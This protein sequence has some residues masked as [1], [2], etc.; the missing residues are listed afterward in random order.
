MKRQVLLPRGATQRPAEERSARVG[1]SPS[2]DVSFVRP[3][4]DFRVAV[5]S[6]LSRIPE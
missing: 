5:S 2:R 6:L 3:A 1:R 4:V